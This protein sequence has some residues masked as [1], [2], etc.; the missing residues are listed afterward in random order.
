MVTVSGCVHPDLERLLD[1][2]RCPVVQ[3]AVG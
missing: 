2:H 3:F 1:G